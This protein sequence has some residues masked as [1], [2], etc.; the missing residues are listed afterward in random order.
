MISAC[1]QN[2][3]RGW[4]FLD[5]CAT[6]ARYWRDLDRGTATQRSAELSRIVTTSDTAHQ[7]GLRLARVSGAGPDQTRVSLSADS[8]W[9]GLASRAELTLGQPRDDTTVLRTRLG[10]GITWLIRGRPVSVDAFTQGLSGGAFLGEARRDRVNGLS[11]TTQLRP[12]AALRMGIV[13]SNSTAGIADYRQITVDLR[14]D[15][16]RR[17]SFQR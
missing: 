15:R 10:G 1:A 3:L 7:L 16:L 11:V 12:G 9:A 8:V 6:A 13:D 5:L 2:H 17:G 14:L 4:T